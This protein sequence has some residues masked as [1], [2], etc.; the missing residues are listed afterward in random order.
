M[1]AL[2]QDVPSIM[3]FIIGVVGVLVLAFLLVVGQV[4]VVVDSLVEVVD[5]LVGESSLGVLQQLVVV[6]ETELSLAVVQLVRVA[7]VVVFETF[8]QL[9][10]AL[11]AA[12]EAHDQNVVLAAGNHPVSLVVSVAFF[13]LYQVAE[14][15]SQ[16]GPSWCIFLAVADD[17][18]DVVVDDVLDVLL[19]FI[20]VDLRQQIRQYL[21]RVLVVLGVVLYL[22]PQQ[23][24]IDR[25][26]DAADFSELPFSRF[27]KVLLE[28][29]H[30]G[31]DA[32]VDHS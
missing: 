19:V 27:V 4:G 31:P 11:H 16:H 1:L 24:L 32:V 12:F 9:L 6:V 17:D 30:V 7:V 18:R 26:V 25:D 2:S 29:H 14:R 10:V 28:L 13:F 21:Q 8:V 5:V 15:P 22:C 3:E 23:L 20:F